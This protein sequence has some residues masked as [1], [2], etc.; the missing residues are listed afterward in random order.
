MND[1][2]VS[3]S[4]LLSSAAG[5]STATLFLRPLAIASWRSGTRRSAGSLLAPPEL[6]RRKRLHR[7]HRAPLV[8]VEGRRRIG[9]SC[10]LV[11]FARERFLEFAGLVPAPRMTVEAQCD[12]FARLR[13]ARIGLPKVSSD[14]RGRRFQLLGREM[15]RVVV[16]VFLDEIHGM[17]HEAGYDGVK[18]V[19]IRI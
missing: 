15:A 11:E 8:I 10:R 5:A 7:A 18:L 12:E 1:Q 2:R 6:A 14:Y 16:L 19:N 13:A 3:V 4:F 9:K 17:T